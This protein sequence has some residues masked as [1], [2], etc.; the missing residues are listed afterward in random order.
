MRL[1]YPLCFCL[2]IIAFG[3]SKDKYSVKPSL[4]IKSYTAEV[5]F[6]G[7]FNAV[8]VYSQKNGKLDGDS[9]LVIRRRY[10]QTPPSTQPSD[11][12]FTQLI[13][14][15]P[16]NPDVTIPASDYA[17]FHFSLP[18]TVLHTIDNL[19]IVN[20]DTTK[21][22]DSLDLGFVLT[23]LSGRASDTVRTGRIVV[24]NQ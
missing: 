3:C 22:S 5:P 16:S 7:N 8:L 21:E 6:N 24:K 17:E 12:F 19:I 2:F 10:N 23:D 14:G 4:R 1:R 13:V 18:Y 9:L 20:G 15:D 11:T